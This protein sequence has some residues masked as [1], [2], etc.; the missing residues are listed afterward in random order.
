L[1]KAGNTAD[2]YALYAYAAVQTLAQ[3]MIGTAGNDPVKIAASLHKDTFNTILGKW[4]FDA[5]GDVRNIS[6][7]M[8]RWHDGRFN[9]VKE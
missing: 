4:N 2:G 6:L 5:K 9:E 8:Y 3:A 1:Q 7:V